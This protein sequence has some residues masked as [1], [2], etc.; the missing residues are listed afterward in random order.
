VPVRRAVG[1]TLGWVVDAMAK[2][3]MATAFC[4]STD[5]TGVFDTPGIRHP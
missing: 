5:A 4:L 2:E 1:A 3:A